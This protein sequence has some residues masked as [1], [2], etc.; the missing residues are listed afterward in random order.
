VKATVVSGTGVL[1]T[2]TTGTALKAAATTGT[3]LRVDGKASF[4]RSGR[5]LIG[6]GKTYVDVTVPGG[7]APSALCFANLAV[8]RSG[9]AVAAVRPAYPATGKVRIYLSKAIPTATYIAW[10]VMG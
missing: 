6:T 10:I 4:S 3:A 7:V 2:A 5:V 9:V 1:A 8:Y